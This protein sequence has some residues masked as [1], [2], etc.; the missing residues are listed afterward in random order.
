MEK[1]ESKIRFPTFPQ[2]RRL[3]T[4]TQ[5]GIRILRARSVEVQRAVMSADDLV[6]DRSAK[7]GKVNEFNFYIQWKNSGT[8]PTKNMTFHHSWMP[9]VVALP[10]DFKFTDLW[11]PNEP[12]IN[13]P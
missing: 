5:Y 12:K 11:A 8:T 2:P 13:T 6:M 9:S 3:R 7:D 10:K 4:I 1:Q